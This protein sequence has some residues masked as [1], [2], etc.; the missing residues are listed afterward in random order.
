MMSFSGYNESSR[1]GH[2]SFWVERLP[3]TQEAA[4]SSPVAPANCS[5]RRRIYCQNVTARVQ[6]AGMHE[7]EVDRE[8]AGQESSAR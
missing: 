8:T 3:V 1:A 5:N 2:S 6:F 7:R 4:G